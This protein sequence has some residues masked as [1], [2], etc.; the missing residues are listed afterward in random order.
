ML[1]AEGAELRKPLKY[2]QEFEL[3]D[4]AGSLL[5]SYGVL[6]R[7][8]DY[9][10]RIKYEVILDKIKN[11]DLFAV[12]AFPSTEKLAP[13]LK[14]I[15]VDVLSNLFKVGSTGSEY[16]P[17][18]DYYNTVSYDVLSAAM[19]ASVLTNVPSYVINRI[20]TQ[21]AKVMRT[22][23]KHIGIERVEDA[24]KEVC[25]SIYNA[26]LSTGSPLC[27]AV[28]KDPVYIRITKFIFTH[29]DQHI[30]RSV[31]LV[32]QGD[33]PEKERNTRLTNYIANICSTCSKL[34][35]LRLVHFGIV[36]QGV[37]LEGTGGLSLMTSDGGDCVQLS[38]GTNSLIELMTMAYTFADMVSRGLLDLVNMSASAL[39][40]NSL[41]QLSSP[42]ADMIYMRENTDLLAY[43]SKL[44]KEDA[45]TKPDPLPETGPEG[46]SDCNVVEKIVERIVYRDA[47]GGSSLGAGDRLQ[48]REDFVSALR[49]FLIAPTGTMQAMREA[50]Q[51]WR[52]PSAN[53]V[54]DF[55]KEA[56]S[57]PSS[58]N[59]ELVVPPTLLRDV[60]Q[61]VQ[62]GKSIAKLTEEV[63]EAVTFM[64]AEGSDEDYALIIFL[65]NMVSVFEGGGLVNE[66][67]VFHMPF[68]NINPPWKE[69][70]NVI[71][72]AEDLY[73]DPGLYD[74]T[75]AY[76][77]PTQDWKRTT[78]DG[79][80]RVNARQAKTEWFFRMEKLQ[81]YLNENLNDPTTVQKRQ[82]AAVSVKKKREEEE[83]NRL[84]QQ[85]ILRKREAM[86]ETIE[87]RSK[88]DKILF[89]SMGWLWKDPSA[90]VAILE[91]QTQT[92]TGEV[93]E[94]QTQ[95]DGS[96]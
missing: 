3:D 93:T 53:S 51:R 44:W 8:V 2:T 85:D 49:R 60:E 54:S 30:L 63:G 67:D 38:E 92:Y 89:E 43:M 13:I 11:T 1:S 45:R 95:P 42:R 96:I 70:L 32:P 36:D 75:G 14:Q 34:A 35:S 9:V 80:P 94:R 27:I 87:R 52:Y 83:R 48:Q 39:L 86:R 31:L 82:R 77:S 69:L 29:D 37:V 90:T 58:M 33:E 20:S 21:N 84:E 10:S 23:V 56:T 88:E 16:T 40:V 66:T 76:G 61:E 41:R 22:H 26:I 24:S 15:S 81:I 57:S 28:D 78:S 59:S 46:S 65:L 17:G 72:R 5:L 62:D 18:N 47:P 25:V 73:F 12:C 55:E 19:A 6:S 50:N 71:L 74:H 64:L 79:G 7:N 91:A 68:Y 4:F